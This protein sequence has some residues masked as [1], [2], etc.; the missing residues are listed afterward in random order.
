MARA[1]CSVCRVCWG[2]CV[3]LSRKRN[4]ISLGNGS[5]CVL[6]FCAVISWLG[7]IFPH[8]T[9]QSNTSS[10]ALA[11]I[12][13]CILGEKSKFGMKIKV[14]DGQRSAGQKLTHIPSLCVSISWTEGLLLQKMTVAASGNPSVGNN[15]P[16]TEPSS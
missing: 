12:P 2:L 5:K 7:S 13:T 16:T 15:R 8:S 9:R 3:L 11:T 10:S 4:L 6:R 14:W 1:V